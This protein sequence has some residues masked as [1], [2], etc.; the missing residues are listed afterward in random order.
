MVVREDV[1]VVDVQSGKGMAKVIGIT[2]KIKDNEK[3]KVVL[4]QS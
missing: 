2:I 4:V 3:R 1:Q